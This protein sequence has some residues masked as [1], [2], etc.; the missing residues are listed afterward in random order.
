MM[1]TASSSMNAMPG[2]ERNPFRVTGG[3]RV[4]R[5]RVA[6]LPQATLGR[7]AK[8]LRGKCRCETLRG[9]RGRLR[10]DVF[11]LHVNR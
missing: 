1:S 11:V 2:I 8:P 3:Y 5:P 4:A 10:E 6:R 7:A 9:L